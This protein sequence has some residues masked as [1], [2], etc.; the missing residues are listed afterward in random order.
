[1]LDQVRENMEDCILYSNL[2]Y[3]IPK[4]GK[5]MLS[6]QRVVLGHTTTRLD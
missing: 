4:K 1:M 3:I 6:N 2:F 5:F